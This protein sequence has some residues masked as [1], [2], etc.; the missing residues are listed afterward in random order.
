M[1]RLFPERCVRAGRSRFPTTRSWPSRVREHAISY[2]EER[3]YEVG[4]CE[5][6]FMSSSSA[7]RNGMCN[8]FS[9]DW[10]TG[11]TESGMLLWVW[12]VDSALRSITLWRTGYIHFDCYLTI[13][14]ISNLS[15]SAYVRA[16][17]FCI[18]IRVCICLSYVCAHMCLHWL[19]TQAH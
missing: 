9:F 8:W 2:C 10:Q 6:V 1:G 3:P 17:I 14:I 19:D 4:G 5:V 18:S 11:H 12:F 13:T 15:N 7:L 16:V